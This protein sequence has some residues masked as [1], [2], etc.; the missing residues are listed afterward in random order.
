[1]TLDFVYAKRTSKVEA[2]IC[3]T[4]CPVVI[5]RSV[6]KSLRA[7]YLA[8]SKP[9]HQTLLWLRK[10]ALIKNHMGKL[11]GLRDLNAIRN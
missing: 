11:L 8:T 1:M 3:Q 2:G 9:E 7:R 5:M 6:A 4:L 10:T